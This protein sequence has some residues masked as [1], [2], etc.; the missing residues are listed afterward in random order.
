M[1]QTA[2][3]DLPPEKRQGETPFHSAASYFSIDAITN[4]QELVASNN[5]NLR[6]EV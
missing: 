1:E 4:C 3:L 5:I 6:S 2:Y